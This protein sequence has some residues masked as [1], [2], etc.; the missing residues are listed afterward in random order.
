MEI[1]RIPFVISKLCSEV[2][3][4]MAVSARPKGLMVDVRIHERL[5][6]VVIG[7]PMKLRQVLINLMGNAI[8]FTDKGTITLSVSPTDVPDEYHFE[9]VDTGIGMSPQILTKIFE[10]FSQADESTTRRFGG[11]GLGTAISKGLIEGMGGHI[12]VESQEGIGS[13]F[14]F[15]LT[16]PTASHSVATELLQERHYRGGRWTRPLNVL[17][18]EDIEVNQELVEIR[19]RQR[20][21]RV[22]IA[23]NG[24]IAVEMYQREEFDL[25]LMDVHMPVLN[26]TDA[27]REI[28]HIEATTGRHIPIIMLTA[29]VLEAD[30]E[31]CLEA[32]A[33]DFAFKPVDFDMLYDKIA[34]FFESQAF[35]APLSEAQDETLEHLPFRLIQ[36]GIGLTIWGDVVAY[37]RALTRMQNDYADIVPR[38]RH[39]C[40]TGQSAKAIEVLHAFKG[41]AGNLGLSALHELANELENDAKRNQALAS[42]RLNELTERMAEFAHDIELLEGE[43]ANDPPSGV[44][45]KVDASRLMALL[46]ALLRKL[47]AADIDDSVMAELKAGLDPHSYALLETQVDNFEF[48]KAIELANTLKETIKRTGSHVEQ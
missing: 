1:E 2:R 32:G 12:W 19:L 13:H 31:M 28:R 34:Q 6:D 24:R 37:R 44:A 25:I 15:T 42:G 30:R 5:P 18:A 11:T 7:D 3:E 29:S 22:A 23:P 4:M 40:E 41:V 21:H 38:T 33:D 48:A 14:H 16:L 9:V 8:K 39:L 35:A 20:K 10:R 47:E 27:T 43:T 36:P 46:T 45:P 26:G 17:Y